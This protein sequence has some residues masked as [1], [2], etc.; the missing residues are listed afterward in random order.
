[1]NEMGPVFLAMILVIT[2]LLWLLFRSLSAVIWS[3]LV[4]ITSSIWTMG[5]SGW[6]GST[7][8]SMVMLTIMLI[9]AV[10]IADAVHIISAYL[11]FRKEKLL[12]PA[13]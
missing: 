2:I 9:L 12:F 5:V 11:F 13:F 8:T 3:I 7:I 1:M 6:F 4:V 10:G